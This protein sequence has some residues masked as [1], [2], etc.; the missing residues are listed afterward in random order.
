VKFTN[1]YKGFKKFPK[2]NFRDPTRTFN[3]E[4]LTIFDGKLDE[5][6]K[7]SISKKINLKT[8]APGMLRASFFTRAFENGGDFSM[9]VFSKDYA[10]YISF[11]GLQSPKR[12]SIRL[13]LHQ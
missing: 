8:K 5:N 6:G 2:Y 11:V 1:S 10:P 12:K 7:V 3:S 4:E 13:F 9:D